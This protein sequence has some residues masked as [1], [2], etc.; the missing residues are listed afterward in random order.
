MG[1]LGRDSMEAIGS[2]LAMACAALIALI[3]ALFFLG[4]PFFM[5]FAFGDTGA[6]GLWWMLWFLA[7]L[8]VL[9]FNIT[10]AI[11]VF[12]HQS[13]RDL[14]QMLLASSSLILTC[15]LTMGALAS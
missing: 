4:L 6:P 15:P 14:G 8:F 7:A 5:W 2:V 3:S 13:L 10:R 1:V 11:E 9:F 12:H